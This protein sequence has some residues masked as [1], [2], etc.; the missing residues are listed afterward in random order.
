MKKKIKFFFILTII[1]F[2]ILN[3]L[4]IP[5]SNLNFDDHRY[6]AH[7]GGGYKEIIYSNS[8]ESI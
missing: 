6:I 4:F 2:I 1:F 3:I 7:A 5:K 8:E